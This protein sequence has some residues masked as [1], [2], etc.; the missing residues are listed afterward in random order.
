MT[1]PIIDTTTAT[2]AADTS[3][4]RRS[5]LTGSVTDA[6]CACMAAPIIGTGHPGFKLGKT[7]PNDPPVENHRRVV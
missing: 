7:R 1:M 6:A 4:L 5:A 3:P 2:R